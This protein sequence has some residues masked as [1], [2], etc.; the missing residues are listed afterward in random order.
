MVSL[1]RLAMNK[2][3]AAFDEAKASRDFMRMRHLISLAMMVSSKADVGMP[4]NMTS[5]INGAFKKINGRLRPSAI[6]LIRNSGKKYDIEK[7]AWMWAGHFLSIYGAT[8]TKEDIL[9]IMHNPDAEKLN[10]WLRKYKEFDLA[11]LRPILEKND[12]LD[13]LV[14]AMKVYNEKYPP[15]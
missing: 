10:E 8:A 11:F 15:V 1:G 7:N 13:E 5:E 9:S 6:D 2:L 4:E 3:G 12:V 14:N